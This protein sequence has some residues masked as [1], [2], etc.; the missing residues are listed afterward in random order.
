[1]FWPL[2]QILEFFHPATLRRGPSQHISVINEKFSSPK[3]HTRNHTRASLHQL[4][5]SMACDHK[6]ARSLSPATAASPLVTAK[7]RRVVHSSPAAV[8]SPVTAPSTAIS[9]RNSDDQTETSHMPEEEEEHIIGC[10]CG[11]PSCESR[12]RALAITVMAHQVKSKPNGTSVSPP[13]FYLRSREFP[14]RPII[15]KKDWT[16]GRIRP[17]TKMDD[18]CD[19]KM[20]KDE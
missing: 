19:Q 20:K 3:S 17:R 9:N 5:A 14:S 2:L 1:M 4:Y 11:Q 12:L 7:R 8:A 6:R 13:S 10:E 15:W 18:L 16:T